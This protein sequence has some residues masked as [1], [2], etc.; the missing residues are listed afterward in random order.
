MDNIERQMTI[1]ITKELELLS[2]KTLS[3]RMDKAGAYLTHKI[4][5]NTPVDT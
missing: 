3:K 5:L 2:A 1:A 4:R